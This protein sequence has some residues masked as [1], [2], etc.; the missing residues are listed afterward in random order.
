MCP[1]ITAA[2]IFTVWSNRECPIT[3]RAFPVLS[4]SL[5]NLKLSK[6][7]LLGDQFPA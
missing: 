3:E 7:G 6:N 4:G 1:T 5:A 2:W